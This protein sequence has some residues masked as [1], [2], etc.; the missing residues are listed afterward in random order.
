M[1]RNVKLIGRFPPP[2]D[3]QSH[4]TALLAGLLEETLHVERFDTSTGETEHVDVEVRFR[5][6]KLFHYLGMRKRLRAT[7]STDPDAAVL[8]ASISP[9]VLGHFRDATTVLPML[10]G[11]S[12]VYAV[13][14]WGSFDRVF[15]KI[16][17]AP[18]ARRMVRYVSGF[19]FLND[20]LSE[21]C[22]EWIPAHK[23]IVIPNTLDEPVICSDGQIAEKQALRTGNRRIRLLFLS[24]MVTA[25]GYL[26]VLEAVRILHGRGVSAAADFAGKWASEKDR[27]SF[28]ERVERYGLSN[29]VKH[30]GMV[31][32]RRRVKALY[33][34]ADVFLLPSYFFEAQPLT[35]IEALN[36]ATPVITVR[37]AGIPDLVRE[38]EEAFYVPVRD[39]AAIADAVEKLQDTDRWMHMS[40]SARRRFDERF[41]R[42]AVRLRW[43]ELIERGV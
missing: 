38:G 28:E 6:N 22:A 26:D 30:H 17:T 16:W 5:W 27:Q 42:D 29:V 31:T 9:S 10:A 34:N 14:H 25:K 40:R 19:V 2:I 3:G 43:L 33:L 1:K 20:L 4:A 12:P 21:R 11:R 18:T 15:K 8:W 35:I 23:R 41:S 37:H 32:D 7:R 24:N 13:I 39:P 36:A